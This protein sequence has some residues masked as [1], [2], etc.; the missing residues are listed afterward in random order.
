MDDSIVEIWERHY[1]TLNEE[2]RALFLLSLK[3][4]KYQGNQDAVIAFH[5]LLSRWASE[6]PV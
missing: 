3:V 4:M 2:K 1:D 6:K 5:K